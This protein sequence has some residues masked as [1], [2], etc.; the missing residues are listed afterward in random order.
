MGDISFDEIPLGHVPGS[1]RP[2]SYYDE[3]EFDDSPL[4]LTSTM[5]DG[6]CVCFFLLISKSFG[7]LSFF[8]T[9]L[10]SILDY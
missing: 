1:N 4:T 3:L 7:N 8:F 6:N 9:K 5:S 2:N 10:L